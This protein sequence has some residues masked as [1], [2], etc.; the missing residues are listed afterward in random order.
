[1]SVLSQLNIK[2]SGQRYYFLLLICLLLAT[3][4]I[5][6]RTLGYTLFIFDDQNHLNFAYMNQKLSLYQLIFEKKTVMP[7][8]YKVWSLFIMNFEKNHIL[9]LRLANILIHFFNA[10]FIFLL[11]R[12]YIHSALLSFFTALIFFVHPAQVESIVWVSSMKGTLSSFLV[13]LSWLFITYQRNTLSYIISITLF[14]LALLT[15]TTVA[16][17]PC[18]IFVIDIVIHN[19][20]SIYKKLFFAAP[21]FIASFVI[22]F[23]QVWTYSPGIEHHILWYLTDPLKKYP[24]ALTIIFIILTGLAFVLMRTT[25]KQRKRG[26]LLLGL[27]ALSVPLIIYPLFFYQ[28]MKYFL[29]LFYYS[30]YK[31]VFPLI[32][33]FDY[34]INSAF[35]NRYISTYHV[36]VAILALTV[37]CYGLKK[38][39]KAS[40]SFLVF[41]TLSLPHL[42]LFFFTF[43]QVS[44]FA[45]RF[46]YLALAPL[47]LAFFLLFKKKS[48]VLIAGTTITIIFLL[49]SMRNSFLW[50]SNDGLLKHSIN[51]N[52]QSLAVRLALSSHY[53]KNNKYYMAIKELKKVMVLYPKFSKAYLEILRIYHLQ[54]EFSKMVSFGIETLNLE[55]EPNSKLFYYIAVGLQGKKEY[56]LSNEYF[57]RY[58]KINGDDIKIKEEILRAKKARSLK[59]PEK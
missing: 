14:F 59:S 49:L 44:F 34:G 46:T 30:L 24:A 32:Y 23:Y 35:I 57:N 13:L 25:S 36:I 31:A 39:K 21:Y 8:F 9:F 16:F 18:I 26:F 54:K 1:M 7:V 37:I 29:T 47:T 50:Y 42:G 15:K 45:D 38:K 3:S 6:I 4:L 28:K 17:L 19:K 53:E 27:L 10:L 22:G 56:D 5:Y 51:Q 52:P 33:S 2:N 43:S 48:Y 55:Q 11:S 40:L 12:F 41:L 20:K 58:L